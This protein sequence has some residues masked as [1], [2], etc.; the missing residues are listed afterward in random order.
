MFSNV[1]VFV[2]HIANVIILL[3]SIIFYPEATSTS[4]SAI[5]HI[6]WLLANL[7]GLFFATT[8]GI[9]TNHMVRIRRCTESL[10]YLQSLIPE[11]IFIF[12]NSRDNAFTNSIHCPLL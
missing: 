1:G 4:A 2:C 3:Y 12:T 7:K 6:F 9:V 5:I 8:A 10:Y 11:I